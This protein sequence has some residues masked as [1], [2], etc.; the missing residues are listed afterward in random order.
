M[1][2]YSEVFL[3]STLAFISLFFFAKFMG[4]KFISQMTL[5]DFIAGITLGSLAAILSVEVQNKFGPILMAMGLWTIYSA[6]LGVISLKSRKARQYVEDV[7]IIL[8]Q[9]GKILEENMGRT[10]IN[11]EDLMMRLREK[12]IFNL[13]DVEFALLEIDGK[14]SVLPKSQKR[15]LTPEDLD[16]STSYEG[17]PIELI[18]DGK[19]IY[20][21]LEQTNLDIQWLK[22]QLTAQKVNS[23]QDVSLAQLT[24]DG[25]L[26]IDLKSDNLQSEYSIK[27]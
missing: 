8:I 12:N 10:R 24:T 22:D 23:V 16:I 26:Y 17:L 20:Q 5:F 14:L 2:V 11:M 19:V 3:R 1:S 25:Q 6:A 18:V 7:P 13:Q 27:D 21:N 9:N 15:S 4:K